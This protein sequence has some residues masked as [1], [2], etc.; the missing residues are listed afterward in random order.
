ML[1]SF[2]KIT[3]LKAFVSEFVDYSILTLSFFLFFL[4]LNK[5]FG[6]PRVEERIIEEKLSTVEIESLAS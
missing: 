4:I 3:F 2:Y 6:K 1:L 5:L